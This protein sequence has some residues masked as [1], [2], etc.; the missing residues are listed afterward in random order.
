MKRS[1]RIFSCV[2]SVLIILSVSAMALEPMEKN[3]ERASVV[4]EQGV[5]LSEVEKVITDNSL[6]IESFTTVVSAGDSKITCGFVVN[7]E[8]NFSN[9]WDEFVEQQTAL[10][11]DAQIANTNNPEILED[12][13][14]TKEAFDN[15]TVY[16]DAV[17][18]SSAESVQRKIFNNDVV[19]SVT[20]IETQEAPVVT[21]E[22]EVETNQ[23]RTATTDNWVPTS[24]DAYV[25]PS[26]SYDD[27]T[28]LQ[29]NF[30][31]NS[32][33]A[34]AGLT[35]DSDSALEGEIV[36]YNY[37]G[38]AIADDWNKNYAYTTNQPN[39][40]RD[41]QALDGNDEICFTV[42]CSNAAAFNSGTQYYWYAYGNRTDSDSCKVKVYFQRGHRLL[43]WSYENPWNIKIDE[44]EIVIRFNEW[45]TANASSMSF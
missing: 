18:C 27:A 42:G 9:L 11:T 26:G 5:T 30:K 22:V 10:L 1:Q 28:Y 37:D 15:N 16:I 21:N 31:W 13:L 7:Q 4:F 2:L 20:I 44:T 32:A 12:I 25:W 19:Q 34:L 33:S 17:V 39:A 14:A 6:N 23:I 41:T 24:G 29:L 36:L 8:D 35:N 38:S 3:M 40:Y 45:N 43:D